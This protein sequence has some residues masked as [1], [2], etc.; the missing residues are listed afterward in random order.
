MINV[1]KIAVPVFLIAITLEAVISIIKKSKRFDTRDTITNVIIGVTAFLFGT[2]MK[3]VAFIYYTFLYQFSLFKIGWSWWEI[4]LCFLASDFVF[5][6]FHRLSHERKIFWAAH[7]THHSSK[8][9]NL[10]TALRTPFHAFHRFLFW[11]PLPLIG[12]D[13]ILML[14]LES[15]SF[16]YQFFIHTQY[17]G[18]LG[19]IEWIFNTPSHHRVHHACNPRYI[20]KNYGGTLIIWDRLFGTFKEEDEQP[21][22]GITKNVKT[23]N[24]AKILFHEYVA[25]FIRASKTSSLMHGIRYLF[26]RTGT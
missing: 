18:K 5:Y 3:G 22:F 8:K 14:T 23:Y 21:Q 20:D 17:I 9:F 12:F 13:P 19:P 16:I 26:S 7:V 6:Y 10:S 1:V 24:P 25:T 11:T 2:L 15:I 4:I